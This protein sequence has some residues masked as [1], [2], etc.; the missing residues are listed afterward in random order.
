VRLENFFSVPSFPRLFLTL[1]FFC[2]LGLKPCN[3]P[4][5]EVTYVHFGATWR[6][7][8]GTQEPAPVQGLLWYQRG[9]NDGAWQSGPAPLGYGESEVATNFSKLDPPMR[10][11]YT[12]VYLRTTFSVADPSRLSGLIARV[13]YD[14]GFLLYINGTE[15]L[16]VNAPGDPGTPVPFD[17]IAK[18]SRESGHV[19][20][21]EL[22]DPTTYLQPGEN[23]VAVQLLNASLVNL[24][25]FFDLELLDPSGPDMVPPRLTA[26]V[27]P[28]GAQLRRLAYVVV[29]FDE[30]VTGVD[31][32]DLLVN[33]RP[34]VAVQGEGAGPYR[35]SL[36]PVE[37]P[38]VVVSWATDHGITDT[39][40]PPNPFSGQSWSYSLN[41]E[42][43]PPPVRINEF[44]ALNVSSLRD[45]DREYPDWIEI[46]NEGS[47]PVNLGGFALTNDPARSDQWVFPDIVIGPGEFLIVF[48]S[49]KDRRSTEGELHTNFKLDEEGEYLGLFSPDTPPQ[50]LSVFDPGF[51]P[52]RPDKSYGLTDSGELRYFLTPT[53]GEPNSGPTAE[54]IVADPVFSPPHGVYDDSLSVSIT[55][56]TEGA[57][58]YYR[59]DPEGREVTS[60]NGTLYSKPLEINGTPDRAVICVRAIAYRDGYLPSRMVSSTYVFRRHVL[61]QPARPPGFP[62]I[63][64]N[65]ITMP[66][67]YAMDQRVTQDPAYTDMILQALAEAPTVS[68][69]MD[70]DDLFDRNRGIYSNGN[71]EGMAWERPCSV[72]FI[73]PGG[74][75]GCQV[76]CGIRIQGGSST[77]P[78]KSPKL[79]FRLAFRGRYGV[80]RLRFPLFPD[81]PVREFNNIILDAHLNLTW[82]HPSAGQ[83][84][85]AQYVRDAFC[86]D[87]QNAMG[88]Y[89]PHAFFANLYLNGVHW[90]MYEIHERADEHFAASYLGGEPEQYDLFK[91]DG[92][93]LMAGTRRAWDAMMATARAGLRDISAYEAIQEYLD[94]ADLCDYMI[95]NIYVGNDDWPRHNWYAARNRVLPGSQFHFFA[96]DSEH[97]LKSV[98]I[99][100]VNVNEPN[101]PAELYTYLRANEE[102][103]VLFGDHVHKHFSPGGVLYVDPQNRNWDEEHP[104]RNMPAMRYM[105]RIQEIDKLI[106]V[107]SARWGDFRRPS[108]PYTRNVE[109]LAELNKLI[110]GYFPNRSRYVLNQF[111]AAGLYPRIP[112]PVFSPSGG[113]FD[114]GCLLTI[115][116]P[117]EA[118]G[119][120]YFTLDGTD[121]RTYGSG[122]VASEASP[123]EEPLQ[124]HAPV[125]VKA[126]LYDGGKWSALT[127]AVFEPADPLIFLRVSEIMYNPPA[128]EGPASRFEFIEFHNAG[129]ETLDLT[130][131][132]VSRG[133]S[134]VFPEGTL[135]PPD[136]FIVIASD[137][138]AFRSRY[139]GVPLAGTYSGRLDDDGETLD[140][141][142]PDGSVLFS[143]WWRDSG[144]WPGGADGEG[145]SLV[146]RPTALAGELSSPDKWRRSAERLGSPGAR[147]PAFG[148]QAPRI[149]HEPS[150]ILVEEGR[151]ARISTI[152]FGAPAP[153][154]VWQRDGVDIPDS[155]RAFLRIGPVSSADDGARYRC[156]VSNQAGSVVTREAVLHVLPAGSLFV[157]GDA[158]SDGRLTVSDAVT[159]LRYLF[160]PGEAEPL[161]ADAFD[162]NDDGRLNIADPLALLGAVFTGAGPLPA[163]SPG[164]GPDPTPDALSCGSFQACGR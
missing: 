4:A 71:R 59:L 80:P 41:P 120:I 148:P 99:N 161:C 90:G 133:V 77:N 82:I 126:R 67:D 19:Q 51:P 32:W 150:D 118:E 27:P 52:Q 147:D 57:S 26:R 15:I 95:M 44:M 104:E 1:L 54:G 78:W 40:E 125:T 37:G 60:E 162:A 155:N 5:A 9:F 131:V 89:A 136:G 113:L 124:L 151:Y 153:T 14:D 56:E 111:K 110:G 83:Q 79:S 50:A 100:Q 127:E 121:P 76:N 18:K 75:K 146:S 164:C 55:T 143:F 109:W 163:P 134:F 149:I 3:L 39:A 140:V 74:R 65:Q 93:Q 157:R 132:A 70:I 85:P 2:T 64:G 72:E 123:Y 62:S 115:S 107:E 22:P 34:A 21:F 137:L 103:R 68:V 108:R 7:L 23:L 102:F 46:Y 11:N 73:F 135:L 112:A 116:L 12:C 154:Y 105:K 48:A 88:S 128:Q 119:T 98:T 144:F 91:H 49:G 63:W 31:P 158:N 47:E 152:A 117:E 94:V 38:G 10:G 43:P 87:L 145:F 30:P 13:D 84:I 130:G 101:S 53:S 42:A 6:F 16:R 159:M 122:E 156:R 160:G 45:K 20:E 66:G 97:V 28:P 129:P 29:T 81:S 33:G 8:P 61:T 96:W 141:R 114:P 92:G 35:F 139:P 25:L 36:P 69:V 142:R 24:D 138:S 86:C 106:A 58:I 17:A